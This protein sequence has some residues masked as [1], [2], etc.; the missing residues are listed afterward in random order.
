MFEV[1]FRSLLI[2][3][4]TII[5][6]NLTFAQDEAYFA[7]KDSIRAEKRAMKA[8]KY[9]YLNPS[10]AAYLSMA[11]PGAGQFYVKSY[12]KIPL[13]YGGLAAFTGIAIYNHDQYIRYKR[14]LN[15]LTDDDENTLVDPDFSRLSEN[16]LRANRNLTKKY[17]D[18]NIILGALFY[19]L[20]IADA[21]VDGHLKGFEVTDDLSMR[22]DPAI[23][24]NG[25]TMAGGLTLNFQFK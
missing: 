11:L 20:Q 9:A 18:L 25:N 6:A 13:V 2:V 4:I 23:Y 3:I 24:M 19:G 5:S 14:S 17:R 8:E 1:Y 22:V 15:N 10:T 12:W 21:Y 16:A 7:K